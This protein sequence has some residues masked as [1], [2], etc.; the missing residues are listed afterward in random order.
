[1]HSEEG[2][3]RQAGTEPHLRYNNWLSY[4]CVS[5]SPRVIVY[6]HIMSQERCNVTHL[7]LQIK[8]APL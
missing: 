4:I 6:V 8:V 5:Q 1:M 7:C 2:G 3:T